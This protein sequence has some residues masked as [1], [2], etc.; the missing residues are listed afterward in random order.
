MST[1]GIGHSALSLAAAIR[2]KRLSPVE[3]VQLSLERMDR[4]NPKIGAV[5]WR[6]DEKTLL[7]AKA[8][9]RAVMQG[10]DLPPFHGVPILVKDLTETLGQPWR[11]ASRATK[12]EPKYDAPVVARM[13]QAGFVF[14]GRSTSPEFG[15]LPVTES[16]LYGVTR[17]PWNLDHTP[18]GSSGGAAAAVASG[19]VPIAHAS[20]GGGSI[21]IPAACT[22][23][24]GLKPSRG[25]IPRGPLVT[26]VLHGFSQDGCVAKTTADVASFLDSS[27]YL[28]SGAW[29]TAPLPDRPYRLAI[30]EKL[31]RLRIGWTLDSAVPA[32]ADDEPQRALALAVA[33]LAK[34]GHQVFP[35]TLPVWKENPKQVGDDF[36]TMWSSGMAYIQPL[37][38][39]LAEPH[40]RAL[41]Q[42]AKSLSIADYI[43]A[44]T[45]LQV[46]ATRTLAHFGSDFD[47]LLTPSMAMEPPR[48]GWLGQEHSQDPI[49]LLWRCTA[50]V[51]YNG[52]CN[53]SGQPAISLPVHIAK[54]GLP[55]G[56]QCVAA[57]WREDLLLQL[58][59]ELENTLNW[60]ERQA[61]LSG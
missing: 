43:A 28:A 24:V 40:N 58:S 54:S 33:T 18:G 29:H 51:P 7:E 55:I 2:A 17:N 13:R 36:I 38:W 19:M 56:V 61:P 25:R 6:N 42:L 48:L 3:A 4:L 12:R 23:L 47:V 30:T 10:D 57:P 27:V 41:F 53:V 1:A 46:F 49:A 5:C 44:L 14:V 26:D 15:T 34:L 50:M 32:Q 9:E 31:P 37:E 45:R 16:A 11:S 35:V 59:Q 8:K 20:D 39:E 22:G 21:R 60:Q 52:W